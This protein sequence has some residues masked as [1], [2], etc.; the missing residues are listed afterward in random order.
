MTRT[1]LLARLFVRVFLS[2]APVFVLVPFCLAP[3]ACGHAREQAVEEMERLNRAALADLKKG[4]PQDARKS[5]LE[6]VRVGKANDAD[7][8]PIM[9]R[10]HL[11]LGALYA[12]PLKQPDKAAAHMTAALERDPEIKLKGSF[13]TGAA[14]RALSAARAD[15]G[16]G[17]KAAPEK[18]DEA[19]N[20]AKA[21]PEKATA[22]AP[23]APPAPP[24]AEAKTPPPAPTPA[25][26]PAAEPPAARSNDAIT[27]RVPDEAPPETEVMLRCAL[28]ADL[29]TGRV[30]LHY[31]PSGSETF[32]ELAMGRS[33]RGI[34]SGVIPSSATTGKL[35][36]YFVEAR[37][38]K[39][40]FGSSDSPN[41]IMLREGAA[42]VGPGDPIPGRPSNDDDDDQ[43]SK[44][45]NEDPLAA[46]AH[47]REAERDR[48]AMHRRPAKRV[49]LGVGLG[50]GFGWQP[51]GQ[52]EFRKD[53]EVAAGPLAGGLIH[54][55]PELGYQVT[56][57]FAVSILARLQFLPAEGSGDPNPGS[58]IEKAFSVLA[59]ASYALGAAANFRP[60][61]SGYVGFGEGFRLRVPR[62]PE[63]RLVRSDTVRG[64]PALVGAG[65]GFAY[66]IGPH[67]AWTGE[68][69]GL[70][71]APIF[72]TIADL[73][74]GVEIGF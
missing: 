50:S 54:L 14:K 44:S 1:K 59:R 65:F 69:R 46:V 34:Y 9:A 66:H 40:S 47:E 4:K 33:K 7:R 42:P 60:V 45:I 28:R 37:A 15:G 53:Q 17:A 22:A 39:V 67:L 24:V 27:C 30:V 29:K 51:G 35:L 41:L 36:Q 56:D 10:T 52:L 68:L 32:V 3:L 25:P 2:R 49:F 16:K 72:A 38:A 13:A 57:N 64:G 74:T 8:E 6:A 71:G 18:T 63:V 26:P 48:V 70:V 58:P 62:D 19:K 5:L 12:G 73:S 23:A 20:A 55:M 43:P 31:R 21:A 11:A 61:L